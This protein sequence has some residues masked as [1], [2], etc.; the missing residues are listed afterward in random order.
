MAKLWLF[1]S[2]GL[3][4]EAL[5]EQ[6]ILHTDGTYEAHWKVSCGSVASCEV[7]LPGQP[8]HLLCV[9][10]N[11]PFSFTM[12]PDTLWGPASEGDIPLGLAVTAAYLAGSDLEESQGTLQTK[13]PEFIAIST[14]GGQHWIARQHLVSLLFPAEDKGSRPYP[15]TRLHLFPQDPRTDNVFSFIA[16]G[17]VADSPQFLYVLEPVNSGEYKL[18]L[19]A[20][21]PVLF[22]RSYE[23]SLTVQEANGIA[24]PAGRVQVPA[25]MPFQVRLKAFTLPGRV[26]YV[27]SLPS[28]PPAEDSSLM[29]CTAKRYLL[30]SPVGDGGLG[31]GAG[32]TTES[33][34]SMTFPEGEGYFYTGDGPVIPFQIQAGRPIRIPYPSTAPLQ[35]T[36]QER[37]RK[38]GRKAPLTITGTLRITNPYAETLHLLVEKPLSGEPLPT[39]SGLARIEKRGAMYLLSWEATLTPGQTLTL[40]YAYLPSRPDSVRNSP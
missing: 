35:A 7:R 6:L 15:A 34:G 37:I 24:W 28:E 19:W 29:T 5:L 9:G 30:L 13:T 1:L 16:I 25:G 14:K 11:L 23:T 12:A 38:A 39:E 32:K 17:K 40:S 36:L 4:Q 26:A 3:A 18:T 22:G 10:E 21:M 33:R 8:M 20:W 27:F 31:E 2:L